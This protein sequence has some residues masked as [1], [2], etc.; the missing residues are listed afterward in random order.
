MA[1]GLKLTYPSKY[2]QTTRVTDNTAPPTLKRQTTRFISLDELDAVEAQETASPKTSSKRRGS[3]LLTPETREALP[4]I[5]KKNRFFLPVLHLNDQNMWTSKPV[6]ERVQF[7]PQIA[8]ET[9]LSNC[10]GVPGLKSACCTMDMDDLEHVLGPITEH[11]IQTILRH[12]RKKGFNFTRSD[13]AIDEE[14]G[15]LLG[16]TFFNDHKV[17]KQSDTYPILRFQ[18]FGTRFACKFLNTH[19]G[20]CNIYAVRPEMCRTYLCKYVS[21]NFLVKTKKTGNTYVKADK[22]PTN[23]LDK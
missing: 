23:S 16:Q 3:Q 7:T 5:Q 14:E 20:K 21:S 9:C 2:R 15:R 4:E 8:E 6:S 22:I 10:C 11:D 18:V 12:F 17:F 1:L 19:N 13:I